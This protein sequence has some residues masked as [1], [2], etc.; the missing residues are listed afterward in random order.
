MGCNKGQWKGNKGKG[1]KE[2]RQKAGKEKE[3]KFATQEQIQN[4]YFAA[5]NV[6]KEAVVTITQKRYKFGM[7]I[8]KSIRDGISFD[9]KSVK[10]VREIAMLT[11]LQ[12][13]IMDKDKNSAPRA[14]AK[15]IRHQIRSCD[16]YVH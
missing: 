13:C 12:D 3:I 11:P 6:V 4:G 14:A 8:A 10:P 9:L 16:A 7:D 5:Y 2:S 1:G 15:G